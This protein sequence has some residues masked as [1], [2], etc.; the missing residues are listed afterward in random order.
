MNNQRRTFVA[1]NI[2]TGFH[3]IWNVVPGDYEPEK[4]QFLDPST[5]NQLARWKN[6]RDIITALEATGPF[7]P[8]DVYPQEKRIMPIEDALQ[9]AKARGVGHESQGFTVNDPHFLRIQLMLEGFAPSYPSKTSIEKDVER[10]GL[11]ESDAASD[12]EKWAKE[13]STCKVV[14]E[15]LCDVVSIRNR[16]SQLLRIIANLQDENNEHVLETSGFQHVKR[17]G[18][19]LIGKQYKDSYFVLPL[20]HNPVVDMTLNFSTKWFR[21]V[22]AYMTINPLD[23]RIREMRPQGNETG[24]GLV[25]NAVSLTNPILT[26]N[27]APLINYRT[28]YEDQDTW[29][30]VGIEDSLS[31]REEAMTYIKGYERMFSSLTTKGGKPI[32]WKISSPSPFEN[33]P[34]P[35]FLF[36]T[37]AGALFGSIFYRYGTTAAICKNCQ[38]AFMTKTKGKQ[39][40]FCSNSCRTQ[41]YQKGR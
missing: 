16:A 32:G 5:V 19:K 34:K 22:F 27:A 36:H 7:I 21:N 9:I 37:L 6:L 40:E 30:Y 8:S 1:R 39:R 25:E 2:K 11:I 35:E 28:K 4:N 33:D 15:P 31:Q 26:G 24:L 3:S 18:N 23:S 12:L 10:F 29:L 38:N 41:N 13:D 14:I 17:G 20:K